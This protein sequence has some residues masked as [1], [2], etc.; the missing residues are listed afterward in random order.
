M[1]GPEVDLSIIIVNRDTKDLLLACL[2]SVYRTVPPLTFEVMLVDNASADGSVEAVRRSYPGVICIENSRN[3]GFA[4]ANNQAVRRSSGRHVALLN[5]DTVLTPGALSTI[6]DF[7]D[8]DTRVGVCGGQLLNADGS[9]QNSI[10]NIPTLAT[11][12]LNKSVLKLLFPKRYP[13][14]RTRIERP[15]EV[16]SVIGAC[17]VVSRKAID[18]VG[19]LDESYFFF[20]EETD[21]CQTI[22]R[23]GMSVYFNPGARIYHLQGQT[24]RKN[25]AAARVEYW[26]SRYI[27]FRKHYSALSNIVLRA[28]LLLRLCASI[29]LQLPAS[30]ASRKARLKLGVNSKLLL[31]HLNGC[32]GNWGL[33]GLA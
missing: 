6:V 13:G 7:M 16:E 4:R 11:E 17:M 24:A 2:E 26:R 23:S 5:T 25:L 9:L 14:K 10:A 18:S 8:S 12:L 28:G 32:P 20:L 22:R 3:L 31:W 27:F 33:A 30:V 1:L 21:W 29:A 15:M 19:A